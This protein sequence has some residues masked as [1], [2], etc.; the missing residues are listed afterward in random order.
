MKFG[1]QIVSKKNQQ[2]FFIRSK[3]TWQILVTL[4]EL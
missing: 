1:A 3:T 4:Q 2:F